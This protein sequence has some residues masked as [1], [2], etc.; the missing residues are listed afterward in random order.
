MFYSS[1]A[2]NDLLNKQSFAN[3]SDYIDHTVWIT[4]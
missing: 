1:S 4:Y 2:M 3:E